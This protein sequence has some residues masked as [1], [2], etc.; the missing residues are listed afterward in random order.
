VSVSALV[1]QTQDNCPPGLLGDWA[2]SRGLALDI[3]RVDRWSELPDP[4][5]YDCAI[6]LGSYASLTG[7]W[8][9]WVAQEV[10]WIRHADAAGVPVLGICFGAQALA[11]ALGGAVRKLPSPELAWIELDTADPDFVG[12]GPWLSLHEDTIIPPPLS[13]ELARSVSG[14]Q[15]FMTG[16]HLGI[17]FHPEV[18]SGLLSRWIADRRDLLARVGGDLL[19]TERECGHSAADSALRLFDAF[20]MHARIA[21]RATPGET[22]IASR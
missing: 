2:A 10:K 14:P 21:V 8:T 1:L 11:V 3:L 19:A 12:A 18:T 20:A 13:Y 7:P 5:G 15:A 9:D 4:S 17:Q 16:S 22:R 6:A